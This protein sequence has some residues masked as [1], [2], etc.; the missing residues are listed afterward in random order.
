MSGFADTFAQS[1]DWSIWLFVTAGALYL[2]VRVARLK[3]NLS[4]PT[5]FRRV[6][7]VCIVVVFSWIVLATY[8]ALHDLG[9]PPGRTEMYD[10]DFITFWYILLIVYGPLIAFVLARKTINAFAVICSEVSFSG[11]VGSQLYRIVGFYFTVQAL[12]GTLPYVI[13]IPVGIS[14]AIVGVTAVPLAYRLRKWPERSKHVT[15]MWNCFGLAYFTYAT[16]M[17]IL[18]GTPLIHLH[19]SPVAVFKYPLSYIVAFG[20]PFSTILHVLIF[21]RLRDLTASSADLE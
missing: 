17:S 9:F 10:D 15:L 3:P 2:L 1:F 14:A 20:M 16:W 8:F 6:Q 21:F 19:P 7:V 18:A 5:N 13:G 11:I 4:S 12:R